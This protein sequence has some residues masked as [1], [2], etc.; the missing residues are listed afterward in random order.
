MVFPNSFSIYMFP[1]QPWASLQV[2]TYIN[3]ATSH[4]ALVHM[5]PVGELAED[6]PSR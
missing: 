1:F 4:V 3:K 5:A 2:S 6:A